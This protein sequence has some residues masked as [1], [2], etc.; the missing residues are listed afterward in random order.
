MDQKGFDKH[1]AGKPAEAII[2]PT[3][4]EHTDENGNTRVLY[5]EPKET[6]RTLVVRHL[7]A[8]VKVGELFTSKVITQEVLKE[9]DEN[10]IKKMFML[11]NIADLSELEEL[12]MDDIID[13]DED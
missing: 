9:L 13:S 8:E 5:L 11:P 6:A 1:V 12:E 4:F 7:G 3:R 2:G 10:I